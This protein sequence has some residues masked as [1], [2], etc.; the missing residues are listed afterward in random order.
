MY[1]YLHN[2]AMGLF[3]FKPPP[4][5]HRD[6]TVSTNGIYQTMHTKSRQIYRVWFL[7]FGSLQMK[8]ASELG[9]VCLRTC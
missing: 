3:P 6:W 8:K 7:F 2:P 1:F 5:G 4:M 9:A